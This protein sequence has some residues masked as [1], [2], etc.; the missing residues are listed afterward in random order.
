MFWLYICNGNIMLNF[1]NKGR[2]KIMMII[3]KWRSNGK[4]DKKF[5][6]KLGLRILWIKMRNGEIYRLRRYIKNKIYERFWV[7]KYKKEWWLKC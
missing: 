6:Y 3:G 1:E 7:G 5:E 4:S 2:N